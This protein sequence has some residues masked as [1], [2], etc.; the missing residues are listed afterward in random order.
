M[1]LF[2]NGHHKHVL[3]F[4]LNQ[5]QMIG[6]RT[7]M[8]KQKIFE[9]FESINSKFKPLDE[10]DLIKTY[11]FKNIDEDKHE[12][13]LARWSE[14]IK[15]TD[16]KLE[17]YLKTYIRAFVYYYAQ[18]ITAKKFTCSLIN[19]IKEKFSLSTEV[20]AVLKLLDELEKWLPSYKKMIDIEEALDEISNNEFETYYRIFTMMNYEHPKPLLFRAFCLMQEA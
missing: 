16:D 8:S 1:D 19:M 13:V 4:L 17:D 10:I 2:L 11:I 20:E 12:G 7:D 18:D 6:I 9:M 3:N 5:V 14:L 15:G